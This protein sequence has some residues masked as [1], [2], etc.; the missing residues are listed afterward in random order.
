MRI[1]QLGIGPFGI[2]PAS[3]NSRK[4]ST[5]T[6]QGKKTSKTAAPEAHPDISNMILRSLEARPLD[7]ITAG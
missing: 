2:S 1:Q 5:A 4:C 6:S 7:T 3:P